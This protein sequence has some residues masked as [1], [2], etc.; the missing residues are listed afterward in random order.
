MN[1]LRKLSKNLM[2]FLRSLYVTE[3]VV[4]D[5]FCAHWVLEIVARACMVA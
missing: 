1:E 3:K 2:H 5:S 4:D